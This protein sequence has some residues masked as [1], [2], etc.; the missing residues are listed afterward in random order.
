ME[1]DDRKEWDQAWKSMPNRRLSYLD[2]I[3]W[4]SLTNHEVGE[5]TDVTF[6]EVPAKFRGVIYITARTCAT[7]GRVTE[8]QSELTE[9]FLSPQFIEFPAVGFGA[10]AHK[11]CIDVCPEI[12]EPNPIPW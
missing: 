6:V 7:C 11:P 9:I 12:D 10:L 4:K 5:V 8:D 2:T 1:D 3:D